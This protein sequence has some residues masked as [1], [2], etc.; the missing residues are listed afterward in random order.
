MKWFVNLKTN[1]KLM[2]GFLSVA[3]L[4]V[5]V[6]FIG[7]YNVGVVHRGTQDTYDRLQSIKHLGD[8]EDS[9][10]RI[11]GDIMQALA[12]PEKTSTSMQ[13]MDQNWQKFH[14]ELAS[15][16]KSQFTKEETVLYK[17]FKDSLDDYE[18]TIGK[19]KDSL[20]AGET[21]TARL[22]TLAAGSK[23]DE[24]RGLMA[25]L[26][27]INQT[28]A[29]GI[30]KES[31][32][33]Y[34]GSTRALVGLNL[35][36]LLLAVGLGLLV[37][38]VITT[39]VKAVVKRLDMLAE[40]DWS[41]DIDESYLERKDEFGMLSN[42]LEKMIRNIR[43]LVSQIALSAQDV[44]AS[45]QQLSAVAQSISAD[46]EEVM[47]STQE[48]AAGLEEV[49]AS[50]EEMNASA[51]EVDAALTE[52]TADADEGNQQAKGIAGKALKLQ[53][54][55][56][57]ARQAARRMYDT[58]RVRMEAAI[59]EARIVD[60]ISTMAANI[61]DIASQTNLLALNAAIEAARAG[62]QGRGFAV[63]AD[64]VRKLAEESAT[65]VNH[66]QDLTKQVQSSIAQV[67][68][69]AN[70]MLAFIN[71]QVM[72]DYGVLTGV[73][74]QYRDDAEMFAELT[75]KASRMNNQILASMNQVV[76]AIESVAATVE[77]SAT[78]AQEIAKGADNSTTAL[79]EATQSF[80][81]LA[82]N[83]DRM[84]DL[85]GQFKIK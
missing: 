78:G 21:E 65:T 42:S 69:N 62:E 77:Q 57:D 14:E 36:A 40:G 53:E 84:N 22:M 35:V 10:L 73:S 28:I 7:W 8:A 49:S 34:K 68:S 31:I 80:I 79:N 71:D 18:I 67:V 12:F 66:I 50:A 16:E 41:V 72:R 37:G 15:Y 48:I 85:V 45:C 75:G 29:R 1:T 64:E 13:Q 81:G 5:L 82:Q 74:G 39:A 25:Q 27:D 70:E 63:V 51:E 43:G 17:Q 19:I 24:V 76:R 33:A 59:Q 4:V 46:M 38:K 60:E 26:A 2:A 61:A 55:S 52:L 44:A 3:F 47:A 83:A 56:E 58:I 6:G 11:R 20:I 32:T 23:G 30:E 9:L 54:D